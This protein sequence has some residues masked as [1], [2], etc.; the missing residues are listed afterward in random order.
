[1]KGLSNHYYILESSAWCQS[2]QNF[3]KLAQF[4]CV[5]SSKLMYQSFSQA[6]FIGAGGGRTLVVGEHTLIYRGST[7]WGRGRPLHG[8]GGGGRKDKI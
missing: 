4:F 7:Q 2:V 1:M 5:F 6:Y 8:G 3:T